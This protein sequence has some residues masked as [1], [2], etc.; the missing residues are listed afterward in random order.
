MQIKAVKPIDFEL[1]RR[2]RV[3]AY[4]RV[5]VETE[6]S[7]HSMANQI[8]YYSSLIK[9]RAD[10]DFV[11]VYADEG[12]T[13]TKADRP[14]FQNLI[15]D[16]KAGKID[17]ILVK[18]IS[19]FAR[20][21]V[22]LLNT[23]RHLKDLGIDVVF[24]KENINS[25]SPQGELLLTLIA[26]FAQEESRSVSENTKWA[27]RKK[28][29]Q[30]IDLCTHVYGYRWDGSKFHIVPEEA[31]IVREVFRRYLDGQSPDQI[32]GVLASRGIRGIRGAL[33]QY[34]SIWDILRQERYI[35]NALLQKTFTENHITKKTIRNKGEMQKFYAEGTHPAIIDKETFNAVQE[36]IKRRAELGYLANQSLSFSCFTGKVFCSE[37]GRTYRRR[38]SGMKGRISKQYR[39]ICGNKLAHTVSF[40]N[41]QNVPETQLYA[42]TSEV[43]NCS[44]F[45][46]KQ[47]DGAVERILVSRPNTL[48]FIMK[49]GTSVTKTWICTTPNTKMREELNGNISNSDSGNTEQICI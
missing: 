22:D 10:W 28:F 6:M 3:A 43:L 12:F 2:K 21:T 30:G 25:I 26:S 31:E 14:G 37:C 33:F 27:I 29:E 35:G 44:S 1:S 19:R 20:N 13:G 38:M 41:S 24:E 7:Q 39:W 9:S 45:D 15:S 17:L 23:V 18:S 49:D 16:C 8:N 4:A 11:G 32:A 40:C 46:K 5:S 36:E 42:L 47:F 34:T 48:T